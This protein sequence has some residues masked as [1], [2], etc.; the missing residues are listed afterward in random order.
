MAVSYTMYNS[1]TLSNGALK[2]LLFIVLFFIATPAHAGCASYATNGGTTDGYYLDNGCTAAINVYSPCE[3]VT[4]NTGNTLFVPSYYPGG[5]NGIGQNEW[6]SFITHVP[7]GVSVASC[8]CG[9]PWGGSLSPGQS[10]TVY[11]NASEPCHGSCSAQTRTCQCSTTGICALSGSYTNQS[12]GVQACLPCN[13]PW[14]G[15]IGDSQSVYAYASSSV[16]CGSSCSG[17]YRS[18]DNGNLSGSYGAQSCSAEPCPCNLPWG[19]QISN[20]QTATAYANPSVS[21]GSSCTSENRICSNGY[22][23]GSY[24]NTSCSVETCGC[25]LPWGGTMA[26]GDSM[27]MYA[28]TPSAQNWNGTWSWYASNCY[29]I[30]RTCSGGVLTGD[31]SYSVKYCYSA[32]DA[33]WNNWG[34]G[35][36]PTGQTIPAYSQPMVPYG[37]TCVPD[38][39]TCIASASSPSTWNSADAYQ[40]CTTDPTPCDMNVESYISSQSDDDAQNQC[41]SMCTSGYYAAQGCNVGSAS[42]ESDSQSGWN[43]YDCYCYQW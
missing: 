1:V 31:S 28:G 5:P 39:I 26:E 37:S 33:C 7:V 21:C 41:E 30:T 38:M 9:L 2:S 8:S 23:T 25:A 40:S 15:Q 42:Y 34:G 27:T 13:L 14:G 6:T 17:Q 19:G 3:V 43:T 16:G 11:A 35:W 32:D 29:G 36:T 22:L 10:A 12:C 4:N 20:G 18:C 24:T